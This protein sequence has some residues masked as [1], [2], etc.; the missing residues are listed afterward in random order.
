MDR[1]EIV[2]ELRRLVRSK[3]NDGVK[4]AFLSG[5]EPEQIDKLDLR[6]VVE[7]KRSE[8]G[9]FEIKFADK[10]KALELLE[11]LC[12]EESEGALDTFLEGLRD[13]EAQ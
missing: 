6:G 4:L 13:G 11:R 10:L 9:C 3:N 5:E 12:R 1:Q 2:R 8:K 7:F